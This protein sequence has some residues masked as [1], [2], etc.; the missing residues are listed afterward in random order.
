MLI[1]IGYIDMSLALSKFKF[2]ESLT[3]YLVSKKLLGVFFGA[4]RKNQIRAD[5]EINSVLNK[6]NFFNRCLFSTNIVV[7]I[8]TVSH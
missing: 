8:L 1:G 4:I 3:H 5:I 7:G 6:K 2:K